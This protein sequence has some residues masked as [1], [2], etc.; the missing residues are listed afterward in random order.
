MKSFKKTF[1]VDKT[2][3]FKPI[4]SYIVTVIKVIRKIKFLLK[5]KDFTIFGHFSVH[6]RVILKKHVRSY[7]TCHD[8][9]LDTPH[10]YLQTSYQKFKN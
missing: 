10:Q 2:T 6:V 1:K 7:S 4:S 3:I 9:Q 8:L 5:M